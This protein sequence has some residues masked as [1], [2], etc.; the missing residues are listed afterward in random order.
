[1]KSDERIQSDGIGDE[2]MDG[3]RWDEKD[4]RRQR[5]AESSVKTVEEEID[6]FR[7][8]VLSRAYGRVE[9]ELTLHDGAIKRTR[10][11]VSE[12]LGETN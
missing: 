11:S 2:S 1:M 9:I 8:E 12:H 3:N 4:E 10:R 5:R 7:Q 6:W